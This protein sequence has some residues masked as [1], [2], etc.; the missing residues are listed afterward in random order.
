[1]NSSGSAVRDEIGTVI[2]VIEKR[3]IAFLK[4][5][6]GMAPVKV[7]RSIRSD[8]HASLRAVTAIVAVGSKA[9]VYI[10]YSYDNALI[11]AITKRYTAGL[12]IGPGEE[13][14]YARETASDIV[15]VI[16]GN[17]TADLAQRGELISLSPPVLTV[18][19]HTIQGRRETTIA[20]LTLRFPEGVLDIAFVG[21]ST[22]FDERLNYLGDKR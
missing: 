5:E 21:P 14:L 18:G 16:V 19:A 17:S 6:L 8:D 20:V 9:G 4:S 22:L 13:E 3:S 12:S 11:R 7:E 10:A 1:M 2:E 15:N